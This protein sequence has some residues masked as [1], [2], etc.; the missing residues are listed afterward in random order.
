[1]SQEPSRVTKLLYTSYFAKTGNDP[2]A[3]AITV[4]KPHWASI[5]HFAPLAPTPTLLNMYKYGRINQ[6]DYAKEYLRILE[7]RGKSPKELADL[8]PTGA[9]LLCYEKYPGFCHRHI[10]AEWFRKGGINI[11]EL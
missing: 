2:L 1:M 5:G 4:R 9:I 3:Y 10:A 6:V 8:L 11:R 7:L